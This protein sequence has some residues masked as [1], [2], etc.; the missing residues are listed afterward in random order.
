M[1]I[2]SN[3][4][5][6]DN[7][8]IE[9]AM[10]AAAI[11]YRMPA[12]M[13][14]EVLDNLYPQWQRFKQSF[15]I[16]LSAAGLGQ[17]TETRKAS[18]LLNC[19]GQAAQELYFNTLLTCETGD[20][21]KASTLKS[22]PDANPKLDDVIKAFEEYFAPKSNEVINTFHFNK[23]SQEDGE[24]FDSFYTQI[25][26][27]AA[28]CNF[29][30]QLNRML[31]DRIIVGIRDHRTQQK[32]LEVKELTLD[33]AVDICRSAE[34]SKEH[35]KVL[36]K[37]PDSAGVDAVQARQPYR[38]SQQRQQHE[39]KAKYS[40]FKNNNVSYLCKKCN[41]RHGPRS[42]PAYGEICSN[43]NKPNH[44]KVGCK[45]KKDVNVINKEYSDESRED[46]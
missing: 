23:R 39:N 33:R 15:K 45:K 20:D 8:N 38:H 7:S 1:E 37:Q 14:L 42:C 44:F 6:D 12:P 13:D 34:M 10:A 11:E 19:I 29:D 3:T 2:K 43:C 35:A 4:S 32:L 46:L 5:N 30:T 18:I 26:K 27:I 36:A 25:R 24:S 40:E 28:N 22:Q 21:A 31:R 17:I 41:T 16:F 9:M